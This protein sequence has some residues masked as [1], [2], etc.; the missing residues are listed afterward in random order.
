FNI[1]PTLIELVLAI[2]VM[3]YKLGWAFSAITFAT[4]VIYVIVTFRITDWRLSHR[5]ALNETDSR[6]AGLSVD[7]LI[8]YETV[9]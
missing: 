3:S 4:I 7:A 9:K 1:G 5:R 8:N 6:A 2:W